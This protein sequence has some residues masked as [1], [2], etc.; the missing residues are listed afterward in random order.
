MLLN[1]QIENITKSLKTSP[2]LGRDS[3]E[4]VYE[5]VKIVFPENVSKTLQDLESFYAKLTSNRVQKL[6]EQKQLI[7]KRL[8]ENLEEEVE[9]KKKLDN[10]MKYLGAHQA[11]DV[12]IKVSD[13]LKDLEAQKEKL[14]NY[15]ELIGNY[16]K[17]ALE[18][19]ESFIKYAQRTEEYLEEIKP[20]IKEKQEFFR[21]L[22]KR[23][24]PKNASGIT[25]IS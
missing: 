13:R 15:E 1:N 6:S 21:S 7:S 16:H 3:I 19:K 9:L 22:A 8:E 11:L 17:K 12:V 14:Q 24:Y 18:I 5:E 4:K 25:C 2:D 23:F 20:V 10:K